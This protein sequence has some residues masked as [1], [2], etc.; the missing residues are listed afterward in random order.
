MARAPI[1]PLGLQDRQPDARPH[2][3]FVL[4]QIRQVLPVVMQHGVYSFYMEDLDHNW[5]EIQHYPGFQNEDLFDFGDRFSMEDGAEV[6]E[7]KE[8]NIKTTA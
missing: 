4:Q 7:L 2:G 6:G 1:L 8:L 3:R 5:W